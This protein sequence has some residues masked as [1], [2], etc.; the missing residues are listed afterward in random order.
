MQ[1][2]QHWYRL[3]RNI[4]LLVLLTVLAFGS[5]ATAQT[6]F[7][8]DY[9]PAQPGNVWKYRVNGTHK[10]SAKVLSGTADVEG[11]ETSVLQSSPTGL[12]AFV[13]SDSDGVRLHRLLLKEYPIPGLGN[14]AVTMTFIPPLVLVDGSIDPGQT[15]NS[16]GILRTNSLPFI[17]ILEFP[18]SSSFTF[19]GFDT[20]TVPAGTFEAI[21]ISGT[22]TVEGEAGSV[23]IYA[24]RELGVVKATATNSLIPDASLEL[25]S[26]NAGYVT[27]LTPNG[28]E[29]VSS[30]GTYPVSWGASADAVQFKLK[31][32]LD[33]GVKW[34][35]MPGADNLTGDNF[36]WGVPVVQGNKK[37]SRLKV[38]GYD[39]LGGEVASDISDG[40]FTIEVV[41]ITAPVADEIVTKGSVYPVTWTTN[42]TE[43]PVSSAKVFYTFGSSGIWKQAN[44]TV[45]DPL[46]R[47]DWNVPSPAKTKI[48]KLKIVL[49]D[50]SGVTVG[51]AISDAFIVQ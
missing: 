34:V 33:D 9:F 38:I 44:G 11:D 7:S 32:S 12:K 4:S 6:I 40:P 49:K 26:T 18:Y 28:G 20:A 1:S 27:L 15:F 5:M 23:V 50:A 14:V 17:G 24:A 36:D 41:S 46:G 10:E 35:Q 19:D 43:S 25:I 21:R 42:V 51:K 16:S 45:V 8:P 2:R 37:K 39:A 47:F 13:S 3:A 29:V 30:G 48:V 22:L 31:Y